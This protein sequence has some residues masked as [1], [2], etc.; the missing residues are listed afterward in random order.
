MG[1][2]R[3]VVARQTR[4]IL[5]WG[6]VV[7]V[8]SMSTIVEGVWLEEV[9]ISRECFELRAVVAGVACQFHVELSSARVACDN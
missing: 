2:N 6:M 9:P 8:V 4:F 3:D 7:G 5:G 1:Q